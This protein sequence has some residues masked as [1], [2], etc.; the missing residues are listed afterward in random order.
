MC[1]YVIN[2]FAYG[3]DILTIFNQDTNTYYYIGTTKKNKE[4]FKI[5]YM[6]S[7]IFADSLINMLY[8]AKKLLNNEK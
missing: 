6:P 4:L 7:L 8:F 1:D 5:Q 3:T 2:R